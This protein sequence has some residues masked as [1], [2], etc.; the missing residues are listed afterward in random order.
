MT[1]VTGHNQMFSSVTDDLT[2]L[3]DAN[4]YRRTDPS[5]GSA[6]F[7]RAL[8]DRF[9]LFDESMPMGEDLDFFLR[10]FEAD[11]RI[12]V[13]V[14]TVYYIRRHDRNMTNDESGMYR[15]VLQAYQKSIHRRKL[16]D[17]TR[18]LD[19]FFHRPFDQEVLIGGFAERTE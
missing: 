1:V 12:L 6:V 3:L 7:R 13:E 15:G 19:V 17:R 11:A 18:R 10:L 4:S 8:F 5:L 14:E 2:P 16:A 9:G